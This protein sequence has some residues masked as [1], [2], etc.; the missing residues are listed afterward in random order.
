MSYTEEELHQTAKRLGASSHEGVSGVMHFVGENPGPV[1]GIT[2]CTHGDEPAGLAAAKYLLDLFDNGQKLMRGTLFLVIQ[3]VRASENYFSATSIIEKRK[4]RFIDINLNRLPK[5]FV[6]STASTSYEIT[7]AKELLPIWLQFEVGLDIHS[8]T[9]EDGLMILS[10]GSELHQELIRGFPIQRI[11]SN[12]DRV[13]IGY[14]AVH[15]YGLENRAAKILAVECG[16]HENPDSFGRAAACA[17]ALLQN[18]KMLPGQPDLSISEYEEYVVHASVQFPNESYELT[19]LFKNFEYMPKGTVIAK[20]NGSP[21]V[22]DA[23]SHGLFASKIKPD[24]LDEEV[25]FLS[26]PVIKRHIA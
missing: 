20:G 17:H 10:L 8:T 13:Q 11:V 22:A 12:I 16:G 21:I 24:T 25:M 3:N 26:Q 6:D 23:D 4:A 5:D 18:L 15:F 7:R 19:K 14:P 1:V 9:Q 2:V